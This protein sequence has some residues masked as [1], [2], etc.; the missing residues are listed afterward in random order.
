MDTSFDDIL[1]DEPVE[2]EQVEAVEPAPEPEP[3]P[4]EPKGE[5]ESAPPAPETSEGQVPYAAL[6]EERRKRQELEAR[7]A[8]KEKVKAPDPVVDP[9]AYNK[10]IQETINQRILSERVDMSE[11]L[12]RQQ[13]GDEAVDSAFAAFKDAL[14]TEPHLYQAVMSSRSPYKAI[15]DW[16]SRQRVLETVG[17]DLDAYKQRLREEIQAELAAQQPDPVLKPSPT[18][19]LANRPSAVKRGDAFTGPTPLEDILS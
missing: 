14:Q 6:K 16:H 2:P 1:K 10:H 7:I 3:A 12:V 15:V 17:T 11:E 18:P 13:V 19:S 9:E 8:E 5:T 4:E